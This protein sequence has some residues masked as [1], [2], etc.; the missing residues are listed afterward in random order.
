M[1]KAAKREVTLIERRI[2]SG[3]PYGGGSLPIPLVEP[4]R[5][6]VRTINTKIADNHL[7]R[8][9]RLGWV[10]ADVADLACDPADFG[11]SVGDGGRITLG[12]RGAEVLMKVPLKQYGVIQKM[13][14]AKNRENT[15]GAKANK[16]AIL[17]AAQNEPGGD[18][19]ADFLN[20]TIRHMD[21]KDSLE[22]VALEE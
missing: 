13:K 11:F 5:W 16:A 22:R 15:F 14:E 21:I 3:D 2:Q 12:E 20:R 17:N 9:L 4:Q 18:Q 19:G 10:Y 6:Y 1:A 8:V 7:A